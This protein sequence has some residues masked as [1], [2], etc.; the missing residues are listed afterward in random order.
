MPLL[1]GRSM[2]TS[3]IPTAGVETMTMSFGALSTARC[4]AQLMQKTHNAGAHTRKMDNIFF[5]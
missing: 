4:A 3:V 5:I 1:S 2:G